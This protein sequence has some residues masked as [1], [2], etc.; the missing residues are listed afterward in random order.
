MIELTNSE[1]LLMSYTTDFI[2]TILLQL[3]SSNSYYINGDNEIIF[4]MI[5]RN[6]I[7][8]L[9]YTYHINKT[10]FIIIL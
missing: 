1:G 4:I 5:S 8:I 10:I 6:K 7:L 3:I 9:D 2:E